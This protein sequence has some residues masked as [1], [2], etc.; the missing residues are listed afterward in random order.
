MGMDVQ[1]CGCKC[2]QIRIRLGVTVYECDFVCCMYM[3]YMVYVNLYAFNCWGIGVYACGDS[4]W[5]KMRSN[6]CHLPLGFT[7]DWTLRRRF[8][9]MDSFVQYRKRYGYLCMKSCMPSC[10]DGYQCG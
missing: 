2:V 9:A 3:K 8:S 1:V 7:N 5:V 6:V 10:M 4:A